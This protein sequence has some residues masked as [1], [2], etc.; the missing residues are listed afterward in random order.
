[1]N[2]GIMDLMQAMADDNEPSRPKLAP[3]IEAIRLRDS[4]DALLVKHEFRPGMIVRQKPQAINY[5]EFGDNGLAIVIE[6]LA[7]PIIVGLDNPGSNRHRER[8]DIIVGSIEDE[9]MF[10][11]FH[12]DSRR[13]EPVE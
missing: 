2:R 10:C 7:E 5:K 13:F 4:Y 12:V 11:L 6:V 3:D 9:R 8:Q 1:M